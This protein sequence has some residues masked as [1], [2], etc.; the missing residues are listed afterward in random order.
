MKKILYIAFAALLFVAC[1][2]EIPV[3]ADGIEPM[4]VAVA[5]VEVDE[6]L[7]LRLTYSRPIFG[8]HDDSGYGD[9]E[10]ITNASVSLKVNGTESG[11]TVDHTGGNYLFGYVP[12]VGDKLDLKVSV[13]GHDDLT[14]TTVVP[15]KPVMTDLRVNRREIDDQEESID[16]R[17]KLADPV[18]EVNYYRL[19]VY[20]Y[21]TVTY[22][23]VNDNNDTIVDI[24]GNDPMQVYFSC[25]DAA[26]GAFEVTDISIEEGT[27]YSELFFT[28][29]DING[30]NHE[31]RLSFTQWDDYYYDE[32]YS[33]RRFF[34]V[35]VV[36][37]TRDGYFYEQSVA[38]AVGG[39]DGLDLFQEPV[40]IHCNIENG[41]GIFAATATVRQ[42]KEA[43]E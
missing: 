18:D 37:M 20:K 31:I 33:V 5:K 4:V 24:Y 42:K 27:T 41:I 32:G 36:A 15:R 40:E 25:S 7:S 28:D 9:F 39:G 3:D 21:D 6:P 14:A 29:N 12:Q 19:R 13:P 17:F 16:V 38:A 23:Y 35:E 10:E 11:V 8:W 1:E 30:E 34:E 2:K 26:L 22:R 43:V